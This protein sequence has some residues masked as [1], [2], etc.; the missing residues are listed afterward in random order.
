MIHFNMYNVQMI[1]IN[2]Y[3][4]LPL[5]T[6]LPPQQIFLLHYSFIKKLSSKSLTEMKYDHSRKILHLIKH[7]ISLVSN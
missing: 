2:E 7:Y 1:Y 5:L 4:C 3:N 6:S